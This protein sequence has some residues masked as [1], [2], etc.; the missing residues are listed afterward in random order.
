VVS[1]DGSVIFKNTITLAPGNM[2]YVQSI[3]GGSGFRYC[4][5]TVTNKT[6]IKG[7]LEVED[8]NATSMILE[9]K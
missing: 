3:Y 8:D 1:A 4:R 6:L 9:A 2:D 7:W 5:F